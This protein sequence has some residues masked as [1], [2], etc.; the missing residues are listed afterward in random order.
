MTKVAAVFADFPPDPIRRPN[1]INMR[2]QLLQKL[3][4]KTDDCARGLGRNLPTPDA[5]VIGWPGHRM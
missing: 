5:A 4:Y 1:R 3:N 2:F